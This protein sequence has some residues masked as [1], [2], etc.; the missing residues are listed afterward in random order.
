M[1]E[2]TYRF[3]P[4]S[5]RGLLLGLSAGRAATLAAG[6]VLATVLLAAGA[7]I[8]PG[9]AV[10]VLAVVACFGRLSGQPLLEWIRPATGTIDDR[11]H[12]RNLWRAALPYGSSPPAG[13]DGLV[14]ATACPD[15]PPEWG[16]G[17]WWEVITGGEALGIVT[18]QTP[19]GH[20]ATTGVLLSGAPLALVGASEREQR[21][22]AW[23]Q[24]LA[25]TAASG[26]DVVGLQLIERVLPEQVAVAGP[27]PR[28]AD[29]GVYAELASKVSADAVSHQVCLAIQV[30]APS[31]RA[32]DALAV[33]GRELASLVRRLGGVGLAAVP[34]SSRGLAGWCRAVFSGAPARAISPAAAGPS[35]QTRSWSSVRTDGVV[36]G[37]WWVAAWPR[38]ELRADWLAPFLLARLGITRTVSVLLEPLSPGHAL[39]A[40]EGEVLAHALDAAQRERAGFGLRARHL[41]QEE[42]AFHREAELVAGHAGYRFAAVVGLSAKAEGQL[43]AAALELVAAAAASGLELRRL[44]GRQGEALAALAPLCRL[45]LAG[46][47]A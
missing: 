42:A 37:L 44:Y 10:V 14:T 18:E 21:L 9:A 33:A 30:R 20:L 12:H 16:R 38:L 7:G 34:L 40:A 24:V 45:R 4:R 17:R 27:G 31:R 36:H 15:I 3:G 13:P 35:A 39:K 8:V 1:A 26:R 11:L 29:L 47:W 43:E 46:R 2:T 41:G 5:T 28:E 6:T 23:G 25:Q 32:E 22:S 19:K